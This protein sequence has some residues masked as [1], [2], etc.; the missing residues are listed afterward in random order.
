MTGK[1]AATRH[2]QLKV[3]KVGAQLLFHQLVLGE[4]GYSNSGVT[5]TLGYVNGCGEE[6]LVWLTRAHA[7]MF[8]IQLACIVVSS[9][10]KV[11]P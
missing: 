6:L 10:R 7:C 4:W 5:A 9:T 1:G 2:L 11:P 3:A 8:W